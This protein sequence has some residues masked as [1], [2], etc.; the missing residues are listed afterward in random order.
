[1]AYAHDD[2]RQLSRDFLQVA[3]PL[4]AFLKT[5]KQFVYLDEKCPE[6]GKTREQLL[7]DGVA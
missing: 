7:V 6:V 1:M 4:P 3:E 2:L 5:C